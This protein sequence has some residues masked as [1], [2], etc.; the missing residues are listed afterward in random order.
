MNSNDLSI[1][2]LQSKLNI[3]N[4][5]NSYN[6]FNVINPFDGSIVGSLPSL[7]AKEAQ[8][9]SKVSYDTWNKTWKHT[10]NK[11]RANYLVKLA[12][13]MEKYRQ[14]LAH[15]IT[16][17]SGKPFA[18][19]L[20]EISYAIS[21]LEL[22]AEEGKRV[23]GDIITSPVRGRRLLAIKQ[24]IGPAALITPW[25]FPSAMITRKLGPAL[26]AG[27][28]VILKPSEETPFSAL[29]ICA[30]ADEVGIPS[31]V[32]QCLTVGRD[33]V[34][35]VGTALCHS[36]YIRKLS[37]TGSNDVGKWLM[38]ECAS[39][40]KKIS[41]ELGGSAPFIVFDDADID[42]AIKALINSKFRNAGQA[43]IASNR[44]LVQAGIYDQF[45]NALTNKVSKMKVGNG[46][47]KDVQIG[48]LI[49][50]KGLQKV[51]RHVADSV[52]LGATVTI[53]GRIHSDLNANGGSFYLPTV[54]T[55][56]TK[57]MLPFREETFGP[58]APLLKFTTDE[59]AIEIANSTKYGLAGYI[60][61][62]D[63]SR[64][65]TVSEAL[66][67]GMIGV[68]E[69]GISH[70]NVPFGGIKESGIGREGGPYG[71]DEYLELKYICMGLGK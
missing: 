14:E 46:L 62:K 30:I 42:V 7:T 60:C 49:N 68:N 1:E 25:N 37:F 36:E 34:I 8:E 64:A 13:G 10:T 54:L 59:E 65:W 63:L 52:A 27:C 6:R 51:E 44:I 45:A 48:P 29:A 20:G 43:C 41:L 4:K 19:S 3:D 12:N 31:G 39:T 9:F 66:E 55:D 11:E 70:E 21:F 35:E 67:F 71:L 32:I 38:R 26:A 58:L 22:Y 50:S 2:N 23:T 53:G 61:T 40:L 47:D 18:E 57:D 15:I 24:P 56:V 17:E 28:T 16:L 5:Y 33:E 69:G